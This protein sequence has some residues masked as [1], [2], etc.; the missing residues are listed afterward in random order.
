MEFKNTGVKGNGAVK[1]DH[2]NGRA[3]NMGYAQRRTR[4]P[5]AHRQGDDNPWNNADRTHHA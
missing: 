1:R 3:A 4:I 5:R 2:G